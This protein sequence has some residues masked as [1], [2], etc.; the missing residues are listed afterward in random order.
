MRI[1]STYLAP[2]WFSGIQIEPSPHSKIVAVGLTLNISASFSF[3]ER[4][5][6]KNR[7]LGV[8]FDLLGLVSGTIKAIPYSEAYFCAPALVLKFSSVQVKPERYQR[9]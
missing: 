1:C 2:F 9:A 8:S 3:D 4:A 6:Q 5:M 7:K